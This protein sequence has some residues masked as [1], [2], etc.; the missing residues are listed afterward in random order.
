MAKL[1]F[2]SP[3]LTTDKYGGSMVG[4]TNYELLREAFDQDIKGIAIH[5]RP[6]DGV[7]SVKTSTSRLGTA[8]AN[9][10]GLCATLTRKGVKEILEIVRRERPSIIWLDSSLLGRIIPLLRIELPDVKIVCFFHNLEEDLILEKIKAGR[11]AYYLA[12][13][14]TRINERMSTELADV[15]V[16]IQ[17]A[18][19]EQL[20]VKF[21]RKAD[22]VFPVCL[23]DS[24]SEEVS[25]TP[26]PGKRY[27]LFVGSDFPPNVEAL[28]YL[29]RQVSPRLSGTIVLAVGKGLERYAA[30][31]QHEKMLISGFVPN[32]AEL[33]RHA[34]VVVAP[35]FSGGGMKVKIA[36]ALMHNKPVVA[37]RFAAIGY[38][39]CSSG[40]V[41]I[42]DNAE[43]F[44]AT[45]D[46]ST[47]RNNDAPRRDYLSFYSMLSGRRSA[48]RIIADLQEVE[49]GG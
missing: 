20:L 35:I 49:R 25:S 11:W 37:S 39:A 38:E 12:L 24:Y 21:R 7:L 15:V 45:I 4:L 16:T 13:I 32:L 48:D 36:E 10:F 33:Y 29:S 9:A 30:D 5:R 41:M 1:L 34:V 6:V 18:D 27:A 44:S 31:F 17:A 14:A 2:I 3:N 47:V 42:V 8:I 40:S 46:N 23:P 22:Y 43:D 26:P 28:Q 19:S